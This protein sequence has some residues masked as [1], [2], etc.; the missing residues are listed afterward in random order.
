MAQRRAGSGIGKPM[1]GCVV[2]DPAGIEGNDALV[3]WTKRAFTFVKVF[4][5]M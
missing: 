3:E 5:R 4:P 2:I 1:K